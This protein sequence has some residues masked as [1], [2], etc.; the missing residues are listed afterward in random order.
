MTIMLRSVF[1]KTLRDQR[2]SMIW[3]CLGLALLTGMLVAIYPSIR[4]IEDLQSVIEAY[5]EELMALLGAGDLADITSPAGYLNVELFGFMVPFLFVIFAVVHGSFAVAGEERAGT[6]ELL[7]STPI[8]RGRLILEKFASLVTL[9][10][11]LAAVLWVVLAVGSLAVGMDISMLLLAEMTVSVALLGLTFGTVAFA[12]G[13]AIGGRGLSVGVAAAATGTAYLLSALSKIASAMEPAQWI[14]PFYYYNGNNPLVNGLNLAH[15][16][17][18]V[19]LVLLSTAV[20]Y[21]GF[22]RRDL[23]L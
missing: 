15:T 20:A 13:S 21:W 17:V 5:P 6:L 23:R 8:P 11:A 14:S 3:W 2:R 9:T 1:L 18:L 12:I 19:A 4:G 16:G 7:L 22:Q 10:G